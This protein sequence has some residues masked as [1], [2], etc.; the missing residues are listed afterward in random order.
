M[1]D[2]F[3]A[4]I[5]SRS[6]GDKAGQMRRWRAR[7]RVR[8]MGEH[9]PYAETNTP[10]TRETSE[11]K[12]MSTRTNGQEGALCGLCD[13]VFPTIADALAHL[14]RCNGDAV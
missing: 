7:R 2:L 9:A 14:P 1:S 5:G 8:E 11:G 13:R 12:S 10:P 3:G 4:M 6:K